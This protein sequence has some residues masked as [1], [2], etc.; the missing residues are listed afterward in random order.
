[1]KQA[2][3]EQFYPPTRQEWRMWLQQHHRMR[4]AVWVVMYKKAAG[5]PTISWSDAVDEALCFGWIDSTKKKLNDTASIQYFTRRKPTSTWSAVNKKKVEQLINEKL[6]TPAGMACVEVAKQNGC[7]NI[8]DD[9]EQLILP[10]DLAQAL[11]SLPGAHS[12]YTSRTKSAKK[13]IL[14]WVMSAK[15]APTRQARIAAI[16]THAAQQ[17]MPPAL[18]PKPPK[19]Q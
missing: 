12:Y 4:T 6:M 16:A 11:L 17:C 8:L 3:I 9:V 19:G 7:W 13:L 10:Q 14:N 2:E 18:V 15:L 1:M 5:V